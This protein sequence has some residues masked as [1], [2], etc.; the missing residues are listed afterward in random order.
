VARLGWSI[1]LATVLLTST[2]H[3]I[4]GNYRDF[5]FFISEADYPGL[6]RIIFKLGFFLNGLILIYVSWLIYSSCKSKSRWYMIH[7]SGMLG[8]LVGINLSLMAIWDIYD[9]ERLHVFTASNV[10]QL[11]LVWGI[12]THIGL[13]DA[14][15]RNK[16]LRYIS[17]STSI[18]AFL[19]M[20]YSIS[21]GL[22][23]YPE[24]VD[25]NWDLNK[26]QPWID[27]AAPLEYLMVFSFMLTLKSFEQ[28]LENKED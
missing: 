17:I 19:G 13:P 8:V 25:G 18:L 20:I 27:W 14:D 4:S 3:I 9:Y 24:F 12:V 26:M 15:I 16:R 28:E 7:I 2:I 6:E 23:K 11:G 1:P 22:E 21:L 10:F 5:P